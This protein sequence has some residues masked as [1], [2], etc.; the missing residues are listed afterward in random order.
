MIILIK[1]CAN[2]IRKHVILFGLKCL[3]PVQ[4]LLHHEFCIRPAIDINQAYSECPFR[5]NLMFPQLIIERLLVPLICLFES[6]M[7]PS[8][9]LVPLLHLRDYLGKLLHIG[10][11]LIDLRPVDTAC[12]IEATAYLLLYKCVQQLCVSVHQV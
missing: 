12:D 9:A 11:P 5:R 1:H 6:L 8:T 2:L 3:C 7:P 10:E 4:D